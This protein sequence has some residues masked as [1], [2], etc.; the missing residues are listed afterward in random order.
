MIIKTINTGA[1]V[2]DKDADEAA[3]LDAAH[4][5]TQMQVQMYLMHLQIQMKGRHQVEAFVIRAFYT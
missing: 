4:L 5:P 2:A 3:D 1:R